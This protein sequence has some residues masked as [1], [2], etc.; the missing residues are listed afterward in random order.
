[1]TVHPYPAVARSKT[2]QSHT[3]EATAKASGEGSEYLPKFPG[4]RSGIELDLHR[5]AEA[6][7]DAL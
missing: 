1:M 3:L 5:T 2:F 7:A 6:A 4:D